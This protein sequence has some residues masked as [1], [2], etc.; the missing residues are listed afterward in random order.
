MLRS[1]ARNDLTTAIAA[2]AIAFFVNPVFTGRPVLKR[3]LSRSTAASDW[4]AVAAVV[5]AP[6][7]EVNT[8]VK[9]G[10]IEAEP[11]VEEQN[12]HS[13]VTI[14][15]HQELQLGTITRQAEVNYRREIPILRKI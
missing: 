6:A 4:A 12:Y 3:L 15:D 2:L 14:R 7:P 8:S 5:A 10:P 9:L 11:I 13:A 1:A